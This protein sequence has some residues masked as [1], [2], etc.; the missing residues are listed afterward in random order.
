MSTSHQR[1]PGSDTAPDSVSDPADLL[2]LQASGMRNRMLA[3]WGAEKMGLNGAS[4]ESYAVAVENMVGGAPSEDDVIRKVLGDLVAS[5][6]PVRESEVRG[7]AEEFLA[8]A[9]AALRG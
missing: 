2:E 8:Q 4:S 5:K 7:K 3:L 9:R 6:L 1:T